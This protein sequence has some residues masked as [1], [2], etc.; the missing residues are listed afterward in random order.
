MA[1]A[2]QPRLTSNP[3][4]GKEI[5][6]IHMHTIIEQVE[7]TNGHSNIAPGLAIIAFI[8]IIPTQL[9]LPATKLFVSN[10]RPSVKTLQSVMNAKLSKHRFWHCHENGLIKTI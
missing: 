1:V 5:D 8:R 6:D 9:A 3:T 4:A 2:H 10:R 7:S